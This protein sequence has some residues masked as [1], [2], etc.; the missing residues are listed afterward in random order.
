M[1]ERR[2]RPE[3]DGTHQE[4]GTGQEGCHRHSRTVGKVDGDG[5]LPVSGENG[6]SAQTIKK[7]VSVVFQVESP[8][9]NLAVQ[10]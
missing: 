5:A 4:L 9:D 7:F 8:V 1:G 6:L 2:E 10:G 3:Q